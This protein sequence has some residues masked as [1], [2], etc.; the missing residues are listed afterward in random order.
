MKSGFRDKGPAQG[1][2]LGSSGYDGA[3]G[4][5]VHNVVAVKPGEEWWA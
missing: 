4:G 5:V 2:A 1:A 3:P